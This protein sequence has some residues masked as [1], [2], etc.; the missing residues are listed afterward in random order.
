MRVIWPK[1]AKKQYSTKGR[2]SKKTAK[3]AATPLRNDVDAEQKIKKCKVG[4]R[5]IINGRSPTG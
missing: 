5:H 1:P 3:L 2:K 4:S